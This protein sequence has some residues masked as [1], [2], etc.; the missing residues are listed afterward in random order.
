MKYLMKVLVAALMLLLLAGQ[1]QGQ[2]QYSPNGEFSFHYANQNQIINNLGDTTNIGG[3][4]LVD[5]SDEGHL[6]YYL[7]DHVVFLSDPFDYSA[8]AD[9]FAFIEFDPNGYAVQMLSNN[10]GAVTYS[11]FDKEGKC[12][13]VEGFANKSTDYLNLWMDVTFNK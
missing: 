3:N 4:L 5:M 1:V 8:D 2:E 6:Y 13:T 11:F 12:K 10:G 9:K 7:Q